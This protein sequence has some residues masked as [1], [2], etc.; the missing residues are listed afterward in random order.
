ML[1]EYKETFS[2]A[3][4]GWPKCRTNCVRLLRPW[5]PDTFFLLE[6]EA[7]GTP[8]PSQALSFQFQE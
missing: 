5:S 6:A 4:G 7:K 1:S 2:P 8:W 3:P